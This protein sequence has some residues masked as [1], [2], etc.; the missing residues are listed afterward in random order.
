MCAKTTISLLLSL[1]A[2]LAHGASFS[3]V[4]NGLKAEVWKADRSTE[5]VLSGNGVFGP[6]MYV[7]LSERVD[8]AAAAVWAETLGLE[9]IAS[10]FAGQYC[11]VNPIGERYGDADVAEFREVLK[12]FG[13][14][15][16][17]KV[18]AIG[19]GATFVNQRLAADPIIGA[20]ASVV[21]IDGAP[22]SR[23]AAPVPA[24]VV[25]KKAKAVAKPYIL[26]NDARLADGGEG[27]SHRFCPDEPLRQ[28]F[29]GARGNASYGEVITQAWDRLMSRNYRYNNMHH[30]QYTVPGAD[31][32]KYGNSEL[33]PYMIP[34]HYGVER[35]MVEHEVTVF[36]KAAG[37]YL[38]YEYIPEFFASA[39]KASVPLMVLLHGNTNDPRTQAETS[40][41]V[42]IAQKEQFFVAE[43][44]WQGTTKGYMAMG[45]DGIEHTIRLLLKK[46]PQLDP[47]RIYAEGLSAGSM[48]ASALGVQK[49]HLFAAVGGHSGG[50]YPGLVAYYDGES[51][52][53]EATQKRGAVEMPYC[54]VC[55]TA[56]KVVK[57]P[58]PD[59]WEETSFF[60][61]WKVYQT[62]ND[63]PVADKLDFA[64]DAFFGMNLSDRERLSTPQGIGMETGVI[65][66]GEVPI[67]KLV[68]VDGYGHWNFKPTAQVMWNYFSQFSRDPATKTLH[69]NSKP[70]K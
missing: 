57:Y 38:W 39:P 22:G 3:R 43:L 49:S 60:H 62:M 54:S 55:G 17:A 50:I 8:S 21:S 66:K 16:N 51:L 23:V 9:T 19:E 70:S 52:M 45:L 42:E 6:V 31:V 12:A 48:T 13:P 53:A 69:Y 26:A 68:A 20:V 65:Y 15:T 5:R 37:K 67:I 41:F 28:V 56:D 63:L 46:Y 2:L 10:E 27:L 40:G 33:I 61:A 14:A 4:S 59:D 30:T 29:F 25:G 34:A 58:Q 7:F 1:M 11:F 35:H 24:F 64:V 36:G 47:S 32:E 18:I 44:E